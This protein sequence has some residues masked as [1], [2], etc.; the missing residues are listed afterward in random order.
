MGIKRFALACAIALLASGCASGP[1]FAEVKSAIPTQ[2]A[3]EG[4]V[5]VYR[6]SSFG[7]AVQ[8][9]VMVND[10][11]AGE[12]QAMGFFFVDL[13]PGPVKVATSTETEHQL[14]FKLDAGQVRYVRTDVHFGLFV[15]RI[16]PQLID[17][18]VGAKEIEECSYTGTPLT[19]AKK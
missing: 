12:S 14:T 19:A 10:R 2:K 3:N 7:A 16:Q 9:N 15:G 8:P 4:R 17:N 13:P 18:A 6:N 1:K 5:Y 11:P